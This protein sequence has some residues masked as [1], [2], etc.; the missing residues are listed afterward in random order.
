MADPV[1]DKA[2]TFFVDLIDAIKVVKVRYKQGGF[3][4]T[5]HIRAGCKQNVFQVRQ[6]LLGLSHNAARHQF[7]SFDAV[8]NAAGHINRA[9]GHHRLAGTN[10]RIDGVQASKRVSIFAR[11]NAPNS[12]NAQK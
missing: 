12:N 1:F 2:R 7:A 3:D 11:K 5:R 8:A 4:H 9:I 10:T 6:R